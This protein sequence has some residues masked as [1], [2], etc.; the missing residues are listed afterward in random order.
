MANAI[1]KGVMTVWRGRHD[2]IRQELAA[3]VILAA[4]AALC[5]VGLRQF[6]EAERERLLGDLP[7]NV[8]RC[9]AAWAEA[10]ERRRVAA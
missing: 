2:C 5:G 6:E 9:L 4:G 7:D 3:G 1:A 10:A 8:R